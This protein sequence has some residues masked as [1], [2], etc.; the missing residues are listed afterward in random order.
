MGL[1]GA[2]SPLEPLSLTLFTRSGSSHL[3]GGCLEGLHEAFPEM[4]VTGEL[5][6]C[7][8]KPQ[9]QAYSAGL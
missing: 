2:A 6:S 5:E 3:I 7:A 9:F 1:D 8:L 4:V